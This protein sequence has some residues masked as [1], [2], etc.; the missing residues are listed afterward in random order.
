MSSRLTVRLSISPLPSSSIFAPKPDMPE[1][2]PSLPNTAPPSSDSR[3]RVES[4]L[5]L[6]SSVDSERR[7]ENTLLSEGDVR[8]PVLTMSGKD[9]VASRIMFRASSM[10]SPTA[11]NVPRDTA[12]QISMSACEG[13]LTF[14][15]IFVM[16]LER[17]PV[18]GKYCALS[19]L[20]R[21]PRYNST[22]FSST[23]TWSVG[24]L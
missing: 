9:I 1:A 3:K 13:M 21:R 6:R 5:S 24:P 11:S 8:S 12:S 4:A 23:Y 22:P 19:S 10:S 7:A 18:S 14:L 16:R 15:V 20:T 2:K 17:K